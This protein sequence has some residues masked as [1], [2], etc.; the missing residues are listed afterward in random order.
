M[1]DGTDT[2]D[3]QYFGRLWKDYLVYESFSDIVVRNMKE[4]CGAYPQNCPFEEYR[5]AYK[6]KQKK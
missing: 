3:L 2:N 4:Y 5:L 6:Y 1:K